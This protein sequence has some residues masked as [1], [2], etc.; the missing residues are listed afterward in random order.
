MT[1]PGNITQDN[2]AGI[3]GAVI[4]YTAPVGTDNCPGSTT[5][6]T[7]GLASGSTFPVGTTTNTFVTTDASGNT[8]SCSFDVIINDNEAPVANCAA[9]FT[10]QLDINGMASI[11]VADIENGS[12]DNCGVATTTIDISDF[13]CADVGPNTVT[14]TVTDVNGNSST[15]TTVV[16]V[17]DNVAPVANC[18][19]PFTIQLDANGEASITVADIENG[20][21]DAC[22]IAS[23]SIDVTDFT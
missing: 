12:T 6:Q 2:D 13:T 14:L 20:S 3:C 5:A 8:A 10:I 15:C 18:A 7:A 11:T 9:P 4:T 1:C 21:T 22:G 23:T 19:A 16:T 17:E